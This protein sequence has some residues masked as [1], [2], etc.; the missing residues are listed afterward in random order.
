MTPRSTVLGKT[1]V[2]S[3]A[4]NSSIFK[5]PKVS[6]M[7]TRAR[8]LDPI[9]SR[10]NPGLNINYFMNI[11]I[12]LLS[13]L[14]SYFYYKFLVKMRTKYSY[15]PFIHAIDLDLTPGQDLIDP[16]ATENK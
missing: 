7:L 16:T 8:T 9:L 2:C 10:Y 15:S 11:L 4:G 13:R 6:D 1:R 5:E 12:M 14:R 3:L